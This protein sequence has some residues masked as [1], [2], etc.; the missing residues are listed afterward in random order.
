MTAESQTNDLWRNAAPSQGVSQP[1]ALGSRLG[2]PPPA[3]NRPQ[4]YAWSPPTRPAPQPYAA[5]SPYGSTAPRASYAQAP[6]IAAVIIYTALFGVFAAIS[7]NGRAKKAEAMGLPG[8]RYWMAFVVTLAVSTTVSILLWVILMVGIG[9]AANIQG[10]MASEAATVTVD[11]LEESLIADRGFVNTD[12]AALTPTDAR[13]ANLNADRYG[14]G[15]WRC[16]VAFD[17]GGPQTFE[18]T[19]ANDG[20]WTLTRTA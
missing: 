6:G 7:A 1:S 12:G 19:V 13:C 20:G 18:V 15:T 3:D 16:A 5:Q 2:S 4:T 9:L 8:R 10:S 11:E 17:A 14:V